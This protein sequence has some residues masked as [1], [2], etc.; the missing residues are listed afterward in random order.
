MSSTRR[1]LCDCLPCCLSA[2]V[3]Q[4]SIQLDLET[5]F[6]FSH[7]VRAALMSG[8]PQSFRPA[9]MLIERSKDFGRSWKVFRYFAEDCSLHFPSVSAGPA[10][11]IDDVVCDSRYSGSEPSTDGEVPVHMTVQIHTMKTGRPAYLITL[12][13]IRLNFTRLFTLG[14][15]LLTRRRRNPQDKYYYSLYNMVVRG[16]CF[17]NGHAGRCTPVHGRCVCQHN[18]A[19]E[20]CERCQDFHHDSPWRPGGENTADICRRCNCHGHSDSCHFDAARYRATS[21][22]SGGVCDGCLHDRTGPQCE[23]CRPFLYQ[24]PQRAK[25]DPHACIPCS[26]NVIGS[27]GPYCSKVGGLCECKPNVIGRCCDTCAPLICFVL[28]PACE[29]DPRGSVSEL[30]DQVRGQCACRAEVAGRR[31]DRCQTGYWG[32]P[33]CRA[34]Q[35][36]GLS[37][38]CDAESGECRSCRE[39]SAGPNCDRFYMNIH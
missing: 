5:V 6:Q 19:G 9:A 7:L 23:Q 22:V 2:G 20:N 3:H 38:D 8:S 14:D 39:H 24:D 33:Q 36:N 28:L 29:C 34:C 17:C 4:V 15:T 21:G 30:C 1:Y 37:E 26:C 18:T 16:S 35:C 11:S 12:T 10:D 13:N 27:L 32:F 25:D 31:C